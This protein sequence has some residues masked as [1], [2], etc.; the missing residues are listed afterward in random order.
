MWPF[1]DLQHVPSPADVYQRFPYLSGRGNYTKTL[2]RFFELFTFTISIHARLGIDAMVILPRTIPSH[3][4]L[5][6]KTSALDM[7]EIIQQ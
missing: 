6:L 4:H 1:A 7:F 3:K 2:H 5:S